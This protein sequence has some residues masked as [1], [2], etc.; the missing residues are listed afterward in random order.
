MRT[1]PNGDALGGVGEAW[2]ALEYEELVWASGPTATMG[3]AASRHFNLNEKYEAAVPP[4]IAALSPTV[5][6]ATTKLAQEAEAEL[7]RFDEASGSRLQAF[8]PILLRSEAASS[9]QI[10]HL[11]A[12]ARQ[13]FT[14]EAVGGGKRNASEIVA[15]TRAMITAIGLSD[16]LSVSAIL[17]MHRVLMDGQVRHTPGHFR[18]DQVWIGKK[19][20]SPIG[21]EFVA[22]AAGRVPELMA[23]L[24][25]YAGR[26][27]ITPLLH[28]ATA[29]AQFETIHPFSDG[30]G[31]TGRALAQGMLRGSGL[32]RN[33][34]V[35]VS[36]GLL[37]DIEGYHE[38]LNEFRSGNLSPIV[39]QFAS[40]SLRAVPNGRQ[41]MSEL[42]EVRDQWLEASRP[43]AGSAKLRILDYAMEHPAFT[44]EAAALGVG[45]SNENIYRA[46]RELKDSG[47]LA[48]KTE[49]NGPAVWRAQA[50]LDAIDR[51]AER[52]G[53]RTP[54]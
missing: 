37:T 30:N 41:L 33:V 10:E 50:V 9:S 52:A 42:D 36:A 47:V 26:D 11:T 28:V 53:R 43:R 29:H 49:H 22:P 35:P 4:F 34:A 13:I 32:T 14:A 44:A 46:L 18:A 48:M 12:S 25:E 17:E 15:N 31:R 5:D 24:A 16:D 40:A 1:L 6:A 27:D 23:D 54:G 38:A 2:P 3:P 8:G 20:E 45:V 19:N 39:E 51:F 7:A 21:A